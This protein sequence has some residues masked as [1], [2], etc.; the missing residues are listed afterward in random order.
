MDNIPNHIDQS[1]LEQYLS[2]LPKE[3]QIIV[4]NIVHDSI[5]IDKEE[6]FRLME[7]AIIKFEKECEKYNL[8]IPPGKI[9][10]EHWL[11]SRFKERLHPVEVIDSYEGVKICNEYPIVILDDCIYSS[12]RMCTHIN[13]LRYK[14]KIKN[15]YFCI[16][17]CTVGYDKQVVS[18]YGAKIFAGKD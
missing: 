17:A 18:D 6:L 13:K 5:R 4:Q 14:S 1:K 8:F 3:D 7:M 9:G 11:I 2:T 16:V 10:S 15:H 12:V